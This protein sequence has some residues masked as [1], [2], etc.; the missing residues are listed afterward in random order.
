MD[1][2][3]RAV[4]GFEEYYEVSSVGRVRSLERT[5]WH[6]GRWGSL[7]MKFPARVMSIGVTTNG[8]RYLKL[9]QPSAK[10]KHCLVHRLVMA[11]HVG[12]AEVG[13]QV[14]H[15]DGDKANNSVENLEYCTPLENLR[16]CIDVL[17]KKRGE[18]MTSKVTE[19]DVRRIRGDVR[20]LKNIA[21]D[22]GVTLQAI[23][24]IKHRKNWAHVI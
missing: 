14:N 20:S 10:P 12:P 7:L 15:K 18:S 13:M 21:R 11:A 23:W 3:W 19:D 1:E 9:K 5:G 4:V 16:H 22:Y 2:I 8:Y 6:E 24:L 17:G